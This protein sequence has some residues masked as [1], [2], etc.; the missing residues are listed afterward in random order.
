MRDP[1]QGATAAAPLLTD[2]R[3]EPLLPWRA[4]RLKALSGFLAIALASA[5][6]S[7][8]PPAA[9]AQ[10]T[11]IEVVQTLIVEPATDAPLSLQL[12]T[13][14]ALPPQ[15]FVRIKGLP[16]ATSL[17]EGHFVVPGTWALPLSSLPSVRI[18]V[19]AAQA[20]A[21]RFVAHE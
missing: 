11:T 3:S 12:R 8:S 2:R 4:S 19:P 16:P 21:R 14:G 10:G 7:W 17:S 18:T 20:G 5:P 13:K 6:L 9:Q 1:L 15:S